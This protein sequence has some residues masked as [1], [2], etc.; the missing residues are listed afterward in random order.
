MVL[1]FWIRR[2]IFVQ[3][4]WT[5]KTHTTRDCCEYYLGSLS[6]CRRLLRNKVVSDEQQLQ[7]ST[8]LDI[9]LFS[10]RGSEQAHLRE[11]PVCS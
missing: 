1:L 5:W 3:G 11:R 4:P 10:S 7:Q 6:R 2:L 9:S 8:L